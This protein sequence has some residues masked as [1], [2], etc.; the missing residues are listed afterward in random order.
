MIASRWTSTPERTQIQGNILKGYRAS[1][2]HYLLVSTPSDNSARAL[3]AYVRPRVTMAADH[4]M[5][6]VA[7]NIAIS[8]SGFDRL[9][10]RPDLLRG[11]PGEFRDGARKRATL[12]GDVHTSSPENWITLSG[13]TDVH[14]LLS[15]HSNDAGAL[16]EFVRE[17]RDAVAALDAHLVDDTATAMLAG[18][19][20]HFGFAD[21][22]SQPDIEG[23]RR[24]SGLG[25]GI[26]LPKGG[27]RPVRL[28]EF[29]LGYPNE[30][31]T[32]ETA[33][34]PELVRNG[35]YLVY[36]KLQ[37]DV[38]R[39]EA[40]L[41]AAAGLTGMDPELVAAKIVG[42]W[43]D[44][45]PL[46]LCPHRHYDRAADLQH[47]SPKAPPNNFRYLPDDRDGYACPLGAHI[48]RSNPRDASDFAGAVTKNTGELTARH[49]IIRRGMPYGVE[50]SED[51]EQPR[52]LV[53][54][55]YN[56]SIARQFETI[57]MEWCNGGNAFGLGDDAD[58]LIGPSGRPGKMTIPREDERPA[59][60]PTLPDLVTTRGSHYLFAPGNAALNALAAGAF[61]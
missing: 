8:H 34:H 58:Y 1:H 22:G 37:Q 6:G 4:P 59:I 39:F 11:F 49:R 7:V 24:G 53:F 36:R 17:T 47:P 12:L 56:A 60:I 25:G 57:Q 32:V 31:N 5:P 9:G 41:D 48:R 26:P 61:S 23:V 16:A 54:I 18:K 30:D 45:V 52:G 43:R 13:K 46:A 2:A 28:G 38:A 14:F 55:C 44:G 3:L 19:R 20:E 35:S 42:R 15:M 51:P 50:W 33:P 21:G 10:I 27:W 40:S 29:V